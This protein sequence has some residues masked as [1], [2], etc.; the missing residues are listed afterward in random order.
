[1]TGTRESSQELARAWEA[2]ET[3]LL[4]RLPEGLAARIAWL[5]RPERRAL[6]IAAAILLILGGILSFLPILGVWMLPLGLALLA[7]DWPGLKPL[8]ER[9][10]RFCE[11][12]WNRLKPSRDTKS[13]PPEP[14]TGG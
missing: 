10:A 2:R 3:A 13:S 5:R 4:A 14:P 11:R 6:R 12:V 9:T 7:D 8:L 1:M